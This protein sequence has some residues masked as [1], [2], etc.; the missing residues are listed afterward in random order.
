[1]K[2]FIDDWIKDIFFFCGLASIAYGIH[3][4]YP[5]SAWVTVGGV[6]LALSLYWYME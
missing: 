2:K 5:P 3:E 4:M 6:L 1:M